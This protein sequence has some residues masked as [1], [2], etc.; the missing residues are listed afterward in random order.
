MITQGRLSV[1]RRRVVNCPCTYQFSVRRARRPGGP[2][3]V[4]P[5]GEVLSPCR[6][7]T[8]RGTRG[9]C[10]LRP[11]TKVSLRSMSAASSAEEPAAYSVT[12]PAA[13]VDLGFLAG[14]G[15]RLPTNA[16]AYVGAGLAPVRQFLRHGFAVPPPFSV[17]PQKYEPS[18][19]DFWSVERMH[20]SEASRSKGA[21][22]PQ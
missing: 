14:C 16:N 22:K 6:E 18:A 15:S 3:T 8:Q 9:Q 12:P 10:P 2:Q 13:V 17:T 19:M 11:Q 21:F 7:S 5:K 20:A 1:A 4:S